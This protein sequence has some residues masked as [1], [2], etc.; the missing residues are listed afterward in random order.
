MTYFSLIKSH[1]A[2]ADNALEQPIA[3][4]PAVPG[5]RIAS[6]KEGEGRRVTLTVGPLT[7][8]ALL[9][10]IVEGTPSGGMFGIG[11]P[12]HLLA[13]P[14]DCAGST[15]TER[16]MLF[17]PNDQRP[18]EQLIAEYK[19]ALVRNGIVKIVEPTPDPS[20]KDAP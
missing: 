10:S 15:W 1:A 3:I 13:K 16:T 2:C 7:H 12:S 6:M 5:W 18:D 17:A 19:E 14:C 9:G 20:P 4:V 8:L 11:V